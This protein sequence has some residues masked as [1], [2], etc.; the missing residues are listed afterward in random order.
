[1]VRNTLPRDV[2]GGAVGGARPQERQPQR[3]VHRG[4]ERQQ[5]HRDEPLVV[6]QR[7]EAVVAGQVL[8]GEEGVRRQ[9]AGEVHAARPQLLRRRKDDSLLLVADDARL[10][11]V[12]VQPAEGQA[13]LAAQSIFQK[14]AEE[15]RRVDDFFRG[16]PDGDLGQR[17]VRGGEDDVDFRR[18]EGHG[19]FPG[20]AAALGQVAGVPGVRNSRQGPGPLG[21]GSGDQ[22]AGRVG[23]TEVHRALDPGEAHAPRL[24]G[25]DA[26]PRFDVGAGNF[27]KGDFIRARVGFFGR[28]DGDDFEVE[29][30]E[31]GGGADGRRRPHDDRTAL[32]DAAPGPDQDLGADAVGVARR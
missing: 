21:D 10:T 27:E 1:M 16:Q 9:G 29:V 32:G 5:L 11:G 28:T 6:V 31:L 12:G 7:D 23:Q 17:D 4:V 22:S 15:A 14:I 30:A 8:A 13:W 18:D 2:E 25:D 19:L 24:G 26:P 3:H 20:H